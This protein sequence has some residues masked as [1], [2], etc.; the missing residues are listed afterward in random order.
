MNRNTFVGQWISRRPARYSRLRQDLTSIRAGTTVEQYVSKAFIVAFFSG[1]ILGI[2]GTFVSM[3]LFSTNLAI[4]PELYNVLNIN[5]NLQDSGFPIA[6]SVQAII[7]IFLFII[8]GVAGFQLVL[9][10]PVIEKKT[11]E[12]KINMGLHNAVAY[13]FAMRRGGAEILTILRSLSEM[14]AVYGEVA[15]EF[16]QVV[17]DADFFG[18][19]VVNALR[20]LSETS[21]SAKLRD[22]L[23]D[24][25]S[26]VES[27]G[28]L[29]QFLQDRVRLLQEEVKFEQKEFL[30]FLGMVAEIYVTVF[31]AGPLFLIV[32]MVVMGMM[33]SSAIFELTMIG[34][35][36]LP[37][38]S[39]IFI[40][41][42]DTISIKDE[43]AVKYVKARWLNQYSDVRVREVT[44]EEKLFAALGRFDKLRAIKHWMAHPFKGFIEK[45]ELS[46]YFSVPAAI[47]YFGFVLYITTW[48]SF[49]DLI[50][51]VDDQLMIALLISLVPFAIFYTVWISKIRNME[52]LIPDFLDRMAGINEVGLNLTQSIAIM[53]RANLG[54][55][56]Y[57][58]QHIHRDIQWGANFSDALVRFE[59]RV[60]TALIAR[61]VTL[62]TKAAKMSSSIGDLLRIAAADARMS[63][64]LRRDRLSEMFVY[65]AIVYLSFFVFIFVI[66][67]I[68]TQF[69]EKLAEQSTEGL[70][71]AGP[72]SNLGKMSL[73]TIERLLY[74]TCLVQGLFSGLIAGMMGESSIKAGV[75]HSCILIIAALIAFN[76]AF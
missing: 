57:E 68:S 33:G 17:R 18:Y 39:L 23:Q 12:T 74:H 47:I 10:Y 15:Y 34:Y 70:S 38:G 53:S 46:F 62:I 13:M 5:L 44:G 54:I 71:M 51:K 32:I 69:L 50:T 65:T 76:F 60:R 2:G 58:I 41:M 11:R 31:I 29:G 56:G 66:G 43:T 49:D 75:K 73:S 52:A 20:H 61:T 37:I 21:P 1:V 9:I 24:M 8:G 7:S 40:L 72:L 22:F 35:V 6:L 48:S 27:G 36:V 63:E 59:L 14:S 25:L 64:Y 42:I 45:P 4:K 30:Q 16:R 67:V 19:D 55:L 26:T 28:D 3:F